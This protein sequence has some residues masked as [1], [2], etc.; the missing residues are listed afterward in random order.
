[1]SETRNVQIRLASRPTRWV[2][3]ENFALTEEAVPEIE[4]CSASAY[5][6]RQ[7]ANSRAGRSKYG[8]A[9]RWRSWW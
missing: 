7:L 5:L 3:E 4:K 8:I 1:M 6:N 9:N 2:T